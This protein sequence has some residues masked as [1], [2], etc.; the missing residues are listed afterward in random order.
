MCALPWTERPAS[1]WTSPVLGISPGG[2]RSYGIWLLVSHPFG[3]LQKIPQQLVLHLQPGDLFLVFFL[4][5]QRPLPG[6]P[7][8]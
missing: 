6:P 2:R 7:S 1:I 3:E 4:T 5:A 8:G